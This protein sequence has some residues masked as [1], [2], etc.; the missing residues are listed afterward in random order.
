MSYPSIANVEISANATF[1]TWLN[2]TNEVVTIL[3]ENII[4]ANS[5]TSN[6]SGN[7]FLIGIFSAN[8]LVAVEG[9]R[10]GN[11]STSNTLTITSNVNISGALTTLT[12]VSIS[13]NVDVMNVT[14]NISGDNIVAASNV[15]SVQITTTGNTTIGGDLTVSANTD[16]TGGHVSI[17]TSDFSGNVGY[18]NLYDHSV[19][20]TGDLGSNTTSPNTIFSFAKATYR[21]VKLIVQSENSTDT[22]TQEAIVVHDGGSNVEFAV[23]GTVSSANGGNDELGELTAIA[24]G[25]N[26]DIQF[27]QNIANSQ[28]TVIAQLI[29]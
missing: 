17:S 5:T 27:Q 10:G 2:R 4:T 19:V 23:Y 1:E 6:T 3:R 15:T 12:D 21:S 7:S 24:N 26:V 11:V 29:K 25:T 14:G 9:I 18:A 13:G 28:C 20:S 16:L 8:T 22:Q